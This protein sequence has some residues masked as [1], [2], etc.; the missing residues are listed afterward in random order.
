MSCPEEDRS[1]LIEEQERIYQ[2]EYIPWS[3]DNFN[4]EE[5]NGT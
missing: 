2:E 3:E 4:D 5:A 1:A